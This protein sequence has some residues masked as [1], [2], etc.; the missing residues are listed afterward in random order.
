MPDRGSSIAELTISKR[1]HDPIREQVRDSVEF[2]RLVW[3][4]IEQ[5]LREEDP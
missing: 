3:E 1:Q 5:S 2:V 4:A